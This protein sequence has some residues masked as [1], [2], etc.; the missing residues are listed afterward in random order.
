MLT[1]NALIIEG[2]IMIDLISQSKGGRSSSAPSTMRYNPYAWYR[3][4]Y[5][6]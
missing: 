2:V 6:G 5:V 3:A 4:P 1:C